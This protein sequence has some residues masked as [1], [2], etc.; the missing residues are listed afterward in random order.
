MLKY[1]RRTS[2]LVSFE[3]SPFCLGRGQL[4]QD[5]PACSHAPPLNNPQ[6]YENKKT[7]RAQDIGPKTQ[8]ERPDQRVHIGL[9]EHLVRKQLKPSTDEE[10]RTNRVDRPSDYSDSSVAFFSGSFE[11][12]TVTISC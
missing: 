8:V 5:Y 4:V 12:H 9:P 7:G 2:Q 11:M 1:G 3:A 6:S 10:Q